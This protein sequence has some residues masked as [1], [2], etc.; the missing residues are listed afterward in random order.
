MQREPRPGRRL[1]R[2][3]VSSL[4]RNARR[5]GGTLPRCVGAL[6]C[7]SGECMPSAIAPAHVCSA[8]RATWRRWPAT[9]PIEISPPAVSIS[10]GPIRRWSAPWASGD[11]G[12]RWLRGR[13][14]RLLPPPRHG[15]GDTRV[16]REDAWGVAREEPC[17]L[18]RLRVSRYWPT[19]C[20]GSSRAAR[21]SLMAG[22]AR[23]ARAGRRLHLLR[24]R[25][26]RQRRKSTK[27]FMCV[28]TLC[29]RRLARRHFFSRPGGGTM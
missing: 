6:A 11:Q 29:L 17:R 25:I 19:D 13:T 10:S 26:G 28:G 16:I 9:C 8:R 15:R 20:A 23:P 22:W 4:I 5:L 2:R 14:A 1:A 12:A 27:V 3:R 21:L 24:A 18:M 7:A